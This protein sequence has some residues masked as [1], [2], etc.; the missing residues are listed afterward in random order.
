MCIRDRY[1]F[2]AL[3]ICLVLLV[4]FILP[5]LVA[6]KEISTNP[7]SISVTTFSTMTRTENHQ[8]VARFAQ[9]KQPDI[10]CLQEVSKPH[11]IKLKAS[12][13]A[14]YKYSVSNNNNLTVFSLHPIKL[15]NDQGSYFSSTVE[16]PK[17]GPTT[18]INAHMPRQYRQKKITDQWQ[19]LLDL[20]ASID[21]RKAILCGDLN[22][23]PNNSIYDLIIQ[24]YGF[25]DAV[26]HG[27][28][29]TF[30]NAQRKIAIFG[31]WARIDYLLSRNIIPYNTKTINVSKLSDHRAVMTYYKEQ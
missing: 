15:E 18:I 8:D 5:S 23:T 14:T 9:K 2:M 24:G 19:K 20:L 30:P 22:L 31:P 12:L 21:N 10:L 28:G 4:P 17:L 1:I 3:A 25:D 11:L 27:Y 29:F 6:K 16:L 26:K 7:H 13:D